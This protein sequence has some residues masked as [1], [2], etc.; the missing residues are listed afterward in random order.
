[1]L[2][3][4]TMTRAAIVAGLTLA[5]HGAAVAGISPGVISDFNDGTEQGWS[6]PKDNTSNPGNFLEVLAAPKLAA[7]NNTGPRPTARP[8]PM[9]A[10]GTRSRSRSSRPN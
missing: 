6:P 2:Y 5:L 1:M 3:G 7:F 10:Y 9:T 8:C 4:K